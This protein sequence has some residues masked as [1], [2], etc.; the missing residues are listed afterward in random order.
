MKEREKPQERW[1]FAKLLMTATLTQGR[2]AA[3]RFMSIDLTTRCAAPA[4]A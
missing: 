2:K 4:R 3:Q 1:Q